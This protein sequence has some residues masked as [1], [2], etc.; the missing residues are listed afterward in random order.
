MSTRGLSVRVNL[1]YFF[2]FGTKE[3]KYINVLTYYVWESAPVDQKKKIKK[4]KSAPC[5]IIFQFRMRLELGYSK[6][7]PNENFWF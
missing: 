4:K 7:K 1:L 6:F 2:I 5:L 3:I